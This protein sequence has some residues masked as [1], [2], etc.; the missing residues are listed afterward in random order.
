MSGAVSYKV[1]QVYRRYL[2]QIAHMVSL[3]TSAQLGARLSEDSFTAL[4]H[5]S[6]AQ[7]YV[8]RA[9]YPV[10]GREVPELAECH[11]VASLLARGATVERHLDALSPEDFD[12]S[13]DVEVSHVAG[14]ARLTQPACEF[15]D[16]YAMPNFFFHL[17]MGYAIL[18][19]EG[20][21][22]GKGDFD[23]FHSYPKGF[24]FVTSA[25]ETA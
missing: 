12:T 6:I 14:E 15:I 10:V 5:F 11:D 24:S 18:R 13:E 4:Q 19:A 2:R 21:S 23:G 8:L 17:S 16:L 7:G 9:V 1:V 22:I 25:A 3:A 20:L